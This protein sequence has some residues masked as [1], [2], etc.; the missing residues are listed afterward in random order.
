MLD[1]KVEILIQDEY[2]EV[3]GMLLCI[4]GKDVLEF[5]VGIG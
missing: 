3:M 4:K 5:G 2:S 1:S